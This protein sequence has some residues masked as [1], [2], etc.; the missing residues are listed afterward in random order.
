[1]WRYLATS[2]GRP[3]HPRLLFDDRAL[4]GLLGLD[5]L[6]ESVLGVVPLGE[7]ASQ[8][9]PTDARIETSRFHERS[10]VTRRFE[11]VS[12]V[13]EAVLDAPVI[14]PTDPTVVP[15]TTTDAPE[16]VGVVSLPHA[17]D[18]PG[19]GT[20]PEVLRDR[21]SSFGAFSSTRT[22]TVEELSVILS[23]AERAGAETNESW[24]GAIPAPS[25]FVLANRIEGLPSGSWEHRADS[26]EL[27]PIHLGPIA[28]ALQLNYYLSNYNLQ[29]AAAVLA[30]AG[31]WS[32][33][34]EQHGARAY[35]LVNFSVAAV[36]QSVNV[37]ATAIG[38][39]SGIVLGFDNISIDEML[40]LDGTPRRTFLFVIIGKERPDA[41]QFTSDIK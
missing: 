37:A 31:N 27:W 14:V 9:A 20:I 16:S 1:V 18:Y 12:R 36:A 26:G 4:N 32:A 39:G 8:G 41:A 15:T 5:E 21:R 40:D 10:H 28:H 25:V 33:A 30:I 17:P 6:D 2:S 7:G 34:R 19:D 35:R 22:T 24:D 11:T 3:I 13:H 23:A 29:E 38:V